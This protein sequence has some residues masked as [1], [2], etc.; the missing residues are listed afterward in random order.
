MPS[1]TF[2]AAGE[3][4]KPR[5]SVFQAGGRAETGWGHHVTQIS[6]TARQ[7]HLVSSCWLRSLPLPN[8]AHRRLCPLQRWGETGATMMFWDL[9]SEERGKARTGTQ[10]LQTPA[11]H[12]KKLGLPWTLIPLP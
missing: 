4:D 6:Q 11:P 12:F 5:P 7:G 9:A 2:R 10:S 3:V 8:C 1:G